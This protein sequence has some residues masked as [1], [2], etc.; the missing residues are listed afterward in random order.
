MGTTIG[1]RRDS[2]KYLCAISGQI[3][4]GGVDLS[5]GDAQAVIA[6]AGTC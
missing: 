6:V 2:A 1:C 5:Q 3:A 4:H